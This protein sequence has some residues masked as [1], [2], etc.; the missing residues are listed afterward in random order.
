VA[1]AASFLWTIPQTYSS[2]LMAVIQ[3]PGAQFVLNLLQQKLGY[4]CN[5]FTPRVQSQETNV[6]FLGI[7]CKL[8]F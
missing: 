7:S 5:I 3:P 2:K 6:F 1:T 8:P 4:T